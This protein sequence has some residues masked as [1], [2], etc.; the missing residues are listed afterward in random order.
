M[1]KLSRTGLLFGVFIAHATVAGSDALRPE[2]P[3]YELLRVIEV[4]GRQG[5]ATDG[6]RYFVSGNTSLYVYSKSGGLLVGNEAA[7][8]DLPRAGNH[9]GDIDVHNGELY[10]GVEFFEDGQGKDIQIAVY[11]AVTLRYRRS[12]PWEPASG[13]V[14]VS[15]VA[16][17]AA[18]NSIWLSD[19]VN[20]RYLYRY[21]LDSGAYAARLHLRAPP[22]WQQGVAYHDGFLYLTADDGD[23][24]DQ[25]VDNLWRVPAGVRDSAAYVTHAHAFHEFRQVGEI[26]GITF[27][28]AAGEMIVLANRG[29]RIVLGMPKGLYPGY[30]REIH[31]LY[32]YKIVE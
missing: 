8:Q 15:G 14:E 20:G 26:E 6:E 9:I 29:K 3:G 28:D 11:D 2:P 13:Q 30:D 23:A 32:V 10:A 19:W 1:A 16:I 4:A 12:I 22:Q 7:L 31:E 21:E 25:E 17:D 24:E 5:V 18:D 27:D